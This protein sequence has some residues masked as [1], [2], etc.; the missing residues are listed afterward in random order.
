MDPTYKTFVT[1]TYHFVGICK[2]MVIKC[3]ILMTVRK[4]SQVFGKTNIS[5]K[6]GILSY[7]CERTNMVAK[8]KIY[9][10]VT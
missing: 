9:V 3:K 4:N 5:A 1:V 7:K 2:T 10:T 6:Q 8:C